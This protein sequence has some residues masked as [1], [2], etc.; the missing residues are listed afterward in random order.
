M[1]WTEDCLAFALANGYREQF[2]STL[3][4]GLVLEIP[5]I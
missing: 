5:R 1:H 4:T 3:N 2:R